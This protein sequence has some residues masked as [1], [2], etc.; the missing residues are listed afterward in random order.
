MEDT[1]KHH[2]AG[3]SSLANLEI[4]P[5][6]QSKEGTNEV[7]EK[8][9]FLHNVMEK[10]IPI[11][12][13]D[14]FDYK[15]V[16]WLRETVDKLTTGAKSTHDELRVNIHDHNNQLL[17]FGTADKVIYFEEHAVL[18]DYKF[19]F[20]FVDDPE[21]NIQGL[22]YGLGILQSNPNLKYVDVYFA[23]ARFH[24]LLGPQRLYQ[25]KT[26]EYLLR[27]HTVIE[28]TKAEPPIY[29]PNT[30]VCLYCGRQAICPALR[31]AM[32]PLLKKYRGNTQDFDIVGLDKQALEK[33]EDP[34]TL[35]KLKRLSPILKAMSEAI[36]KQ[37]STMALEEGVLPE[38]FEIATRQPQAKIKEPE[39]AVKL[40]KSL[41]EDIDLE[42]LLANIKLS[43]KSFE[44]TIKAKSQKGQAAQNIR[45]F[46]AALIDAGLM[47]DPQ[48]YPQRYLR[49]I[50]Q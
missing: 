47:E 13:L 18:V 33:V 19:G 21:H 23:M 36:D 6:W 7:A 45:Y 40:L 38:G 49:P 20:T 26:D 27:I 3:P 11:E 42:D 32:L 41:Y 39:K 5:Q 4:C 30:K 25:E 46:K 34:E 48:D 16:S 17:T 9:T 14:E 10:D 2:K 1:Q 50:K 29:N 31:D 37:A 15:A 44:D 8:G 35:G 22:A 43:A 12:D 28:R 24:D